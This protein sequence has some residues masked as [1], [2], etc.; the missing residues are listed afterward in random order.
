MGRIPGVTM[1]RSWLAPCATLSLIS[2]AAALAGLLASSPASAEPVVNA[3]KVSIRTPA[4][5]EG[6]AN[7]GDIASVDL[8]L[9]L[10]TALF[11]AA[12]GGELSPHPFDRAELA[13]LRQL[14]ARGS[15]PLREQL[16]ELLLERSRQRLPLPGALDEAAARQR[17]TAFAAQLVLRA[18]EDLGHLSGDLDPRF[19]AAL[20]CRLG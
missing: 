10:G 19:I 20:L 12:L 14:I 4:L 3:F 6:A 11:R 2:V 18:V 17:A 13:E 1:K 5:V 8:E 9:I 16:V 15:D 7:V